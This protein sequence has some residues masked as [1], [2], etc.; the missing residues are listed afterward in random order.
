MP[1]KECEYFSYD[2]RISQEE[3]SCYLL[4]DKG[5][6]NELVRSDPGDFADLNQTLPGWISGVPPQTRHVV[7]Y[8]RVQFK[9]AGS[10][11]LDLALNLDN[12]YTASYEVSLRAEPFRGAVWID[13]KVVAL[14]RRLLRR[15]L[16]GLESNDDLPIDIVVTPRRI[17]LYDTTQTGSFTVHIREPVTPESFEGTLTV[18]HT[19]S[20][21]DKAF[22]EVADEF[23]NKLFATLTVPDPPNENDNSINLALVISVPLVAVLLAGLII[24]LFY[25]HKRNANESVWKI[26]PEELDFADPP[27]VIGRGS[28]GVVLLGEYRGTQVAVKRVIP[29]RDELAKKTSGGGTSSGVNRSG[30]GLSGMDSS[31]QTH[32]SNA[33][34]SSTTSIKSALANKKTE[35]ISPGGAVD[36]T[37]SVVDKKSTTKKSAGSLSTGSWGGMSASVFRLGGRE[38]SAVSS[39]KRD[40]QTGL[41]FGFLSR[42]RRSSGSGSASRSRAKHRSEFLAE[43]N[44]LSRLRHP[45]ITTVMGAV[46][47]GKNV[48]PMVRGNH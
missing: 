22:E 29:P 47:G 45:C 28:F 34:H 10:D 6:E 33:G 42:L 39:D 31:V 19:I 41:K 20:S 46:I 15:R 38:S 8:A 23:E 44:Q 21:C 7:E 25:E 18:S 9:Q 5:E 2:Q 17:A 43:M 1:L 36:M 40:S 16:S 12:N 48:E 32:S 13:A 11:I 27:Q 26:T 4:G 30:S 14:Q 37:G 35:T 3:H 24:F